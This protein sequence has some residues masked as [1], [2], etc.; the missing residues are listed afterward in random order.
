MEQVSAFV[1]ILSW[2]FEVELEDPHSGLE[3]GNSLEE[4]LNDL[5]AEAFRVVDVVGHLEVVI[6]GEDGLI[7]GPLI[8]LELIT[9]LVG[10][11]LEGVS[12]FILNNRLKATVRVVDSHTGGDRVISEHAIVT[13]DLGEV[14]A[15]LAWGVSGGGA[16]L[17][18]LRPGLVVIFV[19]GPS[20]CVGI[21]VCKPLIALEFIKSVTLHVIVVPA[22]L[23]F[24]VGD[25]EVFFVSNLG[26]ASNG[27]HLSAGIGGGGELS[28]REDDGALCELTGIACSVKGE[29]EDIGACVLFVIPAVNPDCCIDLLIDVFNEDIGA[30][31]LL[32]HDEELVLDLI[33]PSLIVWVEPFVLVHGSFQFEIK[34]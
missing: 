33:N 25:I 2:H 22:G 15:D 6:S 34:Q 30:R 1:E 23:A 8:E 5:E 9:E 14:Q 20:E 26:G 12:E 16:I 32:V 18:V 24:E 11:R 31:F 27:L 19:V 21:V 29:V 28:P 4:T 7:V 13:A 17:L 3:V 10:G